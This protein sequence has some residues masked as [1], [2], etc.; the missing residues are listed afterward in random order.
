MCY[1]SSLKHYRSKFSYRAIQVVFLDYHL[2]YKGYKLLDIS[3][4]TIFISKD[5]IFHKLIFPFKHDQLSTSHLDFFS[6]RV[7]SYPVNDNIPILEPL[8]SHPPDP[9][10][11][12]ISSN[13]SLTI[14]STTSNRPT[15]VRKPPSYLHDYLY[16]F[17]SSTHSST[18]HPFY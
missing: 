16:N 8:P 9:I 3:T 2:G 15:Q 13:E 6:N 14:P 1:A 17:V 7:L 10:S 12:Y 5:V 11:H 4:N 18:H